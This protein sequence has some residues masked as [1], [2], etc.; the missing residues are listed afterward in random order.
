MS[1]FSFPPFTPLSIRPVKPITSLAVLRIRD[2]YLGSRILIFIHPGFRISD[3]GSR[4]QNSNKYHKIENYF[5]FELV[6]KKNLGQFTKNYRAFYPMSVGSQKY[7]FGIRDPEKIYSGS[8]SQGSKRHRIPGPDPQHWSLE[9]APPQTTRWLK[10]SRHLNIIY[11]TERRNTKKK[12]RG[13]HYRCLNWRRA[14]IRVP[15]RSILLT[16]V[17]QE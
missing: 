2:V 11:H 13:S 8:R 12:K 5:I 15:N 7:G 16:F 10:W 3:L 9:L 17:P 14:A 6:K 4:I 1:S